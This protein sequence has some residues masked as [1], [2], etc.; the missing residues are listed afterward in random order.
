MAGFDFDTGMEIKQILSIPSDPKPRK[1]GVDY[2]FNNYCAT[3]RISVSIES[4]QQV[5]IVVRKQIRKGFPSDSDPNAHLRKA[6]R[7]F[8]FTSSILN[9]FK[10]EWRIITIQIQKY[11]AKNDRER[12]IIG[13]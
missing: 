11:N 12:Y 13:S 10:R 5:G 3:C 4:E 1:K 9:A 6:S 8:C 2:K 7:H